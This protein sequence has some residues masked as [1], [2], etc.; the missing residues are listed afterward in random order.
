MTTETKARERWKQLYKTSK[1]TPEER[2]AYQEYIRIRQGHKPTKQ[3]KKEL[4]KMI[5]QPDLAGMSE[6]ETFSLVNPVTEISKPLA[7]Q[8]R[9]TTLNLF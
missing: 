1:G 9:S 2:A 3:E 7:R 5:K 8:E 6:C 4:D